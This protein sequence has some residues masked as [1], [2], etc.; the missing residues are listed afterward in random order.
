VIS[1]GQACLITVFFDPDARDDTNVQFRPRY[2]ILFESFS[3]DNKVEL[4]FEAFKNFYINN[5]EVGGMRKK[6][7]SLKAKKDC[8]RIFPFDDMVTSFTPYLKKKGAKEKLER[9]RSLYK[10]M[11]CADLRLFK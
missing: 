6:M 10:S 2:F 5:Q 9:L 7:E 1:I 3:D 11:D 4:V 8:Y